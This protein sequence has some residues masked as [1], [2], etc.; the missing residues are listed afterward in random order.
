M[1]SVAVVGGVPLMVGGVLV[2]GAGVVVVGRETVIENDGRE[3]LAWPSLTEIAIAPSVP[4]QTGV[5][6]SVP[7]AMLKDAQSGLFLMLKD[8]ALPSASLALGV[9]V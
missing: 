6:E 7:V 2:P 1:P 9:K 8:S 4:V 5:P 3:A